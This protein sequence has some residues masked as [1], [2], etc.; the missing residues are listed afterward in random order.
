M[1]EM[2]ANRYFMARKFDRAVP[3][4]ERLLRENPGKTRMKKKLIICYTQTG[5]LNRAEALFLEVLRENPWL[6]I[7][8]DPSS[9]DC[10]CPE[11]TERLERQ[12]HGRQPTVVDLNQMGI[13]YLYCNPQASLRCFR[14]SLGLDPQQPYLRQILDILEPIL[15]STEGAD[16]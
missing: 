2:L 8:T 3:I 10:P 14:R 5:E 12:L 4:L 13:L 1:S 11:L 15:A 9:E 7:D 16:A 6:I